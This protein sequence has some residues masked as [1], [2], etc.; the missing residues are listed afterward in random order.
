MTKFNIRIIKENGD[1][2]IYTDP[3]MIEINEDTVKVDYEDKSVDHNP[4][5]IDEIIIKVT[6]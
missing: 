4:E 6:Q 1:V 5:E 3:Y 2:D